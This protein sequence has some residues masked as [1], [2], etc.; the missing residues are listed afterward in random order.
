MTVARKLPHNFSH[1]KMLTGCKAASC[2]PWQSLQTDA[3][4]LARCLLSI[5]GDVACLL[6]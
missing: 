2:W 6:R 4:I 5:A 3:K 1:S